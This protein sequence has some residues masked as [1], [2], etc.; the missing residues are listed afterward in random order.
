MLREYLVSVMDKVLM[1]AFL[2]DDLPQ[3]LQRPGRTRVCGHTHV[4]QTTCAVLNDNEYVQ[5]SK[6]GSD[7]SRT[8]LNGQSCEGAGNLERLSH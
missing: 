6:R 5:H 4:G 2:A 1:P 7:G 8:A 3:L